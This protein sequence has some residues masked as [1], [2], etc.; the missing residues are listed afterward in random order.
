VTEPRT[1]TPRQSKIL[2]AVFAVGLAVITILS[3]AGNPRSGTETE[4]TP[5]T[6][7]PGD[8]ATG[9]TPLPT[10]SD[11][12]VEL[13]DPVQD[14]DL[15]KQGDTILAAISF[16]VGYD[17]MQAPSYPL[18]ALSSYLTPAGRD[19]VQKILSER[20]SAALNADRVLRDVE[21][22]GV[23]DIST[24][25]GRDATLEPL[26][27]VD[28]KLFE[29]RKGADMAPAGREVWLVALRYDSGS[30]NWLLDGIE[31]RS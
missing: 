26:F 3:L 24:E 4:P 18:D 28:V 9:P 21:L 29:S 6:S 13:P 1:L 25:E 5:S 27:R 8:P 31:P 22:A 16:V 15:A 14:E 2:F 11:Q 7:Q 17:Y 20:D 19:A 10:G 30:G 23:F 12:P